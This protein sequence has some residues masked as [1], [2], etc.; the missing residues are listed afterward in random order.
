MVE[1]AVAYK[2]KKTPLCI[3]LLLDNGATVNYA[4][5]SA[6]LFSAII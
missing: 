6:F 3:V 5:C 2:N 4:D 1:F